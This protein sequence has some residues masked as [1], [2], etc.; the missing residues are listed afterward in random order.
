MAAFR[1]LASSYTLNELG[2][3]FGTIALAVMVYDRTGS[4][5]ATT[6]LFLATSFAPALIA[7]ALTARLDRVPAVRALPAL[8]VA[9]AACFLALAA[10]AEAPWLPAILAL[11]LLDGALAIVGRAL[12]RASVA[13]VLKPV[14][15]LDQ[16]NRL[17]NVAFSATFAAGPALAGL[18][19]ATAGQGASLT[20]T[21][22]LFLVMAVTLVTSRSLPPARADGDGDWRS[23]LAGG[24]RYVRAHRGIHR[25]LTAHA[26]VLCCA[27]AATPIEVVYAKASLGGGDSTYGALL[28]AWGTGTVLSSLLLARS[29]RTRPLTLVPLAAA[30]IGSGYLVM[31][32]APVLLVA[33]LGCL[34]GGAGNG[35]Y[36]VSVVQ[37]IQDRIPDALQARIMALLESTTAACFGVGYVAGGVIAS[38][39]DPRATF[40]AS[41]VGV[42]T[43]ACAI[44]LLLRRDAGDAPA[45]LPEPEPELVAA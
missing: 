1:R 25:I 8:Y 28:A 27:A 6:A 21:A 10:L 44:P 45:E 41:G 31:A 3:S 32:G 16:G 39:A 38:L 29:T 22:G 13:A 35:M 4:A 34:V 24:M 36:F 30:L 15:L 43:V 12:T 9:E 17:L 33:L 14:G 40:A 37:A 26:V 11:A 2:W 7:P 23:R 5:L 18:V 19:V 42:L 20:V